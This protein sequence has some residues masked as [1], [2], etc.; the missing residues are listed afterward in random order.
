M[1]PYW[2]DCSKCN[3][4]FQWS[5]I[6]WLKSSP[7]YDPNTDGVLE[8]IV[9][10]KKKL[11]SENP[12]YSYAQKRDKIGQNWSKNIHQHMVGLHKDESGIA[13]CTDHHGAWIYSQIKTIHSSNRDSA[14]SL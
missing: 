13:L 6:E 11:F 7:Y 9:Y 10:I 4:F 5:K 2:E 1:P 12:N 8:K 3:R 14:S